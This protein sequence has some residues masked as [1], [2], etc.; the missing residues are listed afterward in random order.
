MI[1]QIVSASNYIPDSGIYTYVT[2]LSTSL[3][4][5]NIESLILVINEKEI[6]GQ[7]H[8]TSAELFADFSNF[9]ETMFYLLERHNP[10]IFHFHSF[11]SFDL[12]YQILGYLKKFEVRIIFTIHNNSLLC[13]KG[14]MAF[15]NRNFCT[16]N[17]SNTRCLSCLS[18]R[19]KFGSLI[20]IANI[21]NSFFNFSK[22]NSL[23]Y[24]SLI[25]AFRLNVERILE[26]IDELILLDDWPLAFLPSNLKSI[27]SVT[28]IRQ[29]IRKNNI[30]INQKV[31]NGETLNL[32]FIGRSDVTKG[33]LILINALK[34]LTN[35]KLDCYIQ[36]TDEIYYESISKIAETNK[37]NVNFYPA[38]EH[39]DVYRVF[40]QYD[41]L[42]LPS[43]SEMAPIISLEALDFGIPIIASDHPSFLSQSKHSVGMTIFKNGDSKSL[44]AKIKSA[45][46]LKNLPVKSN[47]GYD[48]LVTKHINLYER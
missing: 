35:V 10:I 25:T 33:L 20:F 31:G 18:N 1:I 47:F 42:C 28:L 6:S 45:E 40:S 27:T 46:Y 17:S 30:K 16:D 36:I 22:K 11:F 21:A 3:N 43:F 24:S 13:Y 48:E 41:L 2:D 32:L 19:H 38:V 23:N 29:A 5:H 8:E 4:E 26:R 44:R 34:G 15:H 7:K 39:N 14:N 9:Q 37:L 12:F